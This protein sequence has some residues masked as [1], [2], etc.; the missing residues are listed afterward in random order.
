MW[1]FAELRAE[2][3]AMSR[4]KRGKNRKKKLGMC[5]TNLRWY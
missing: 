2:T 1:G 5:S 4:I 3:F